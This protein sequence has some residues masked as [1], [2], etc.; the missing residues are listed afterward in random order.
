MVTGYYKPTNGRVIFKREDITGLKPNEIAQRGLV[1]T[2][3]TTTLFKENTV[4]E[5]MIIGF[6]LERKTSF[7]GELFKTPEA[8]IRRKKDKKECYRDFGSYD[9]RAP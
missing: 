6:H 1:R 2:F 5:N 9:V 7:W 8:T 3:Q 4:L